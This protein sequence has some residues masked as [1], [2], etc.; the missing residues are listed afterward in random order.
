M[1]GIIDLKGQEQ[2]FL[3]HKITRQASVRSLSS[4]FVRRDRCMPGKCVPPIIE[5]EK[6]I[7]NFIYICS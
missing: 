3:Q 1:C 7:C 4:Y 2:L 6:Q 5:L